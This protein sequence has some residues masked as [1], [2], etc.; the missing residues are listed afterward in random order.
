MTGVSSLNVKIFADGADMVAIRELAKNPLIKGFT[1]NPTLMRQAGVQDYETFA[2]EVLSEITERPVS[3]EVFADELDEMERQAL[4]IASWGENV[5]V[6]IPITNTKGVSTLPI[7]RSLSDQDVQCNVTAIMTTD[8]VKETTDALNADVPAVISVF[9]GRIAD[10]GIIPLP[11]MKEC[12]EI[13]RAKPKA[14]VLWA[15]PRE[16]LNIIEADK[17]GCGI[18][19]VTPQLLNK[20]SSIG[21]DLNRF[22]IETVEMFYRD[23][24]AAGYTIRT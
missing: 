15:S 13:A 22:S 16:V 20:L 21:K 24:S 12:V 11:V 1:T 23:A 6:K 5:F 2:H 4:K 18:I 10:T 8:Q 19:T 14:E 17:A 3:F 9:A 7:V